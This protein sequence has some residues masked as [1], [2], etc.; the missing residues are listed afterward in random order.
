MK[1][2]EKNFWDDYQESE[3]PDQLFQDV[4]NLELGKTGKQ[5]L[6]GPKLAFLESF[7]RNRKFNVSEACRVAGVTRSRFNDWMRL[8]PI[9]SAIIN[10]YKESM[11]DKAIE[12][13]DKLL[14][15][16]D[17]RAISYVLDRL[18][19]SRGFDPKIDISTNGQSISIH[20]HKPP[21]LSNSD[22]IEEVK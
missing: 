11:V 12:K 4:H 14:D 2:P 20:L 7:T 15:Q 10:D 18:G 17:F 16:S 9:F 1:K 6:S 5:A 22:N 13:L 21:Q 19:K 3:K 8:D